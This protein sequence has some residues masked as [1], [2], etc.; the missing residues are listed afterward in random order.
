M[1]F[2][3]QVN[4]KVSFEKTNQNQTEQNKAKMYKN[5]AKHFKALSYLAI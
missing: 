5:G 4:L 1:F 2:T 3:D